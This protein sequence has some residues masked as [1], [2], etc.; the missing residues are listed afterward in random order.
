[1]DICLRQ[2]IHKI[3]FFFKKN[4]IRNFF[5]PN[6]VEH[7]RNISCLSRARSTTFLSVE[8]GRNITNFGRDARNLPISGRDGRNIP[9]FGRNGSKHKVSTSFICY[10]TTL[11]NSIL[12]RNFFK[13]KKNSG[14]SRAKIRM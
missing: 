2:K 7:G 3:F 11:T 6:S 8:H 10:N 14:F 1:M 4:C 13:E 12:E 5:F 9:T